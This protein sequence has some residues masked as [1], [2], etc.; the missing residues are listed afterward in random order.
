M[1]AWQG[2]LPD[3]K[4]AVHL[5]LDRMSS[6]KL[7]KPSALQP[8]SISG[9]LQWSPLD[10]PEQKIQPVNLLFMQHSCWLWITFHIIKGWFLLPPVNPFLQSS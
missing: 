8:Q 6:L 1:P 5:A 3:L 7:P 2:H 9:E 10:R 4:F